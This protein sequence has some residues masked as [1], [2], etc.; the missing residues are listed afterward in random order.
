MF[1]L[2]FLVSF[3]A[4]AIL[5]VCCGEKKSLSKKVNCLDP[6][7][8]AP[9]INAKF[10][11]EKVLSLVLKA[12]TCLKGDSQEIYFESLKC[13]FQSHYIDEVPAFSAYK[14]IG[15][16]LPGCTVNLMISHTTQAPDLQYYFND[17]EIRMW[18]NGAIWNITDW[19]CNLFPRDKYE[20][21]IETMISGL[22]VPFMQDKDKTIPFL[23]AKEEDD[24]VQQSSSFGI[25]IIIVVCLIFGFVV[26][27]YAVGK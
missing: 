2:S 26:F 25:H 4:I 13:S 16:S 7:V 18:A 10:F 14:Y 20:M 8:P 1:R 27:V 12:K 17:E 19:N 23:E 22:F 6:V 5:G 15:P 21:D 9:F 24:P 11:G 3:F